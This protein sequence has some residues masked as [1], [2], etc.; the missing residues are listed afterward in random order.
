[1][2][3]TVATWN[4]NSVRSRFAQLSAWLA[5]RQPD[6]LCLQ[7]LKVMPAEVPI[8]ALW[9]MGY[10]VAFV[11]QGIYN[12]VAIVARRPMSD[13]M[14]GGLG[15][16]F[17]PE[18]RV[19]AASV[20]GIRVV[21]VYVPHG[22]RID[23]PLYRHKQ[24]FLGALRAYLEARHKPT[25]PIL[26]CGDF[27]VAPE[28]RDVHDPKAWSDKVHYHADIRVEYRHLLAFGLHDTFRRHHAG[29]GLH[30]WWDYRA[31]ALEKDH[32]LR[33]D[34]ILATRPLAERCT[35]A[36][37]DRAARLTPH[38]SDHAPVLATFDLSATAAAT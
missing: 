12:G 8:A 15:P 22:Q 36:A 18:A 4:I 10:Q 31:G 17:D 23:A 30:S 27:N 19:V 34:H 20:A 6:V 28:S 2:N 5:L 21:C 24:R 9:S 7:E 1:M 14:I 13:V 38:A 26:V 11:A 37:I 35:F 3:L 33:I 32:G 29:A 25:D 16:E